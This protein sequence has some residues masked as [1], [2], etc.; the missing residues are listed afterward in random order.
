M[1]IAID[2]TPI[3]G[4]LRGHK[5]RGAGFYLEYLKRA[6]LTYFPEH[7]YIFF[8]RGERIGQ[9]VDLIHYPYF[10]PFFVTLPIADKYK[11][12][13]TVHDLTP[14]VFPEHFPAG[15]KGSLRWQ[16][17]KRNL[18]RTNGI[19]T[20]SV[21]SQKDISRLTG[22]KK[23]KIDIVYLAAAEEFSPLEKKAAHLKKLQEKY[24]IPDKFVLY[25]GD[26]TWNKNVPRLIEAIKEIN[27][28]LVLVGKTLA[29]ENFDRKNAWNRD[30]VRSHNLMDGDKRFI[31]LGFVPTDDLVG[32]YNCAT[33]FVYP[34]VY[35]GFGLPILEAMQSGCPT[36]VTREGCIP[37][38][39]GEG[40]FYVDGYDVHSIANGIGEVFY[41]KKL[42]E[43]LSRKGLGQAKKF[44][45]RKTAEGTI[46]AY[47]KALM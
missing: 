3:T 33:V 11:R 14:I 29:E 25:V 31:R 27:L 36:V 28:T 6:L 9:A 37:E 12:V 13:V 20:D 30:L 40:G 8:S 21:V 17:Q 4:T 7:E 45:W 5:V 16:I 32:L 23:D 1:K 22:V 46:A 39:A 26:I 2:L 44:T 18:M 24:Q 38:V 47:K 35:E 34:S 10:E 41:T 19:I 43:L 15:I 42:Q